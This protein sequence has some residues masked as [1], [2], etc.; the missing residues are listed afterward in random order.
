MSPQIFLQARQQSYDTNLFMDWTLF[1]EAWGEQWTIPDTAYEMS[2]GRKFD[3]TDQYTSGI[4]KRGNL[5][6]D[7]HIAL[8]P[9]CLGFVR[10]A[11][12]DNAPTLIN[13]HTECGVET[14]LI[15]S[16]FLVLAMSAGK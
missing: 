13:W 11:A 4:Y 8:C 5:F 12:T 15:Q 16:P 10:M 7:A 14:W 6:P 9:H 2:S 3:S 1:L